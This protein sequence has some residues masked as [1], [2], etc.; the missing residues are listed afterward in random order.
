MDLSPHLNFQGQ[1]AEAFTFYER[2][3]GGKIVMM[4]THGDSPAKDQVAPEWRDKVIHACLTLGDRS[5]LGMDAPPEHYRAPQGSW[6][7]LSVPAADAKR[8]FTALAENGSVVMPFGKTFWSEGFG[9]TVDR[10]G[11]P[12]MIGSEQAQ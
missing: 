10:F 11:V 1:C 5:L 4:M 8:V 7:S 6:V 3:L 9:M 12:W 2:T